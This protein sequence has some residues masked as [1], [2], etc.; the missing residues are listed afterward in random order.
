MAHCIVYDEYI[1]I[2]YMA[3]CIVYDDEN[4]DLMGAE[5]QYDLCDGVAGRESAKGVGNESGRSES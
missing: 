2:V 4:G 1:S 3:H 5:S